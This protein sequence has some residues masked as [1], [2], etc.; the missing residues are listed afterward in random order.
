MALAQD[1]FAITPHIEFKHLKG[2]QI[3]LSD[4]ITRIKRFSLYNETAAIHEPHNDVL[5][6]VST[7]QE[8]LEILIFDCDVTWQV[9]NTSPRTP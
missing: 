3:I 7:S 5:P 2:S 8:N 9:L 6:P 4:A 1:L